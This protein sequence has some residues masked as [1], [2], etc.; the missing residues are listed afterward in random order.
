MEFILTD[1]QYYIDIANA[2]RR[3]N[4][5]TEGYKPKEMANAIENLPR[6][7]LELLYT[8]GAEI[9]PEDW[10]SA[11]VFVSS[12]TRG[13]TLV[14]D[15]SLFNNTLCKKISF[16]DTQT[17]AIGLLS[18]ANLEEY[19]SGNGMQASGGTNAFAYMFYNC[20]NLK[21]LWMG[22]DFLP[23]ANYA[24]SGCSKLA[25]VHYRG[26]ID[27]WAEEPRW[28]TNPD[29]ATPFYANTSGGSFYLGDS[30]SPLT[31]VVLT[32]ASVVQPFAF[33]R[34]QN[35]EK[36]DLGASVETIN[37]SAFKACTSLKTLILRGDT[38]KTLTSAN[39][40][41]GT[42][43]ADINSNGVILVPEALMGEYMGAT[44]WAT[45][46]DKFQPGEQYPEIWGG[47]N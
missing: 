22:A 20:S 8:E 45:Y 33:Y 2:I 9:S 15:S 27:R 42:P 38:V 14:S 3:K 41:E 28:A 1:K 16:P 44:N 47:A 11:N 43:I 10:G 18:N 37:S 12:T 31:E 7:P 46:T 21:I 5:S 6:N 29:R 39:A 34:F 26:T 13:N 36:V 30:T 24:F 19:D 25:Q 23:F 4:E 17:R 40:F 32:T 35:I